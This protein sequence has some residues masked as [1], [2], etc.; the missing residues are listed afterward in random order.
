MP[1][2]LLCR[3]RDHPR[4]EKPVRIILPITLAASLVASAALAQDSRKEELTNEPSVQQALPPD[5]SPQGTRAPDAQSTETESI[6]LDQALAAVR[7]APP[8]LQGNPVPRP[9]QLASEPDDVRESS[10]SENPSDLTT[11]DNV[12]GQ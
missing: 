11:E 7:R 2:G 6:S 12:G 10:R 1:S 3:L 9:N 4:E 8:D 5:P